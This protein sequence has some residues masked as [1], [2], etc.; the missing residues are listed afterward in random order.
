MHLLFVSWLSGSGH[1]CLPT[2][3]CYNVLSQH[4]PR[5]NRVKSPWA[6]TMNRTNLSPFKL[7]FLGISPLRKSLIQYEQELVTE[8]TYPDSLGWNLAELGTKGGLLSSDS[9]LYASKSRPC[10]S[11]RIL[12]PASKVKFLDFTG[13]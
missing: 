12:T 10:T 2:V 1:L 4:R 13:I 3:P 11:E 9:S 5:N 6:E 8:E 7:V